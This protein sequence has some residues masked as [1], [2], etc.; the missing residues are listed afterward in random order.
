M[1]KLPYLVS[2]INAA[3]EVYL[4]GRTGQQ[5]NRTAFILCDDAVELASKL[6]L[7]TDNKKWSDKKPGQATKPCPMKPAPLACPRHP[8]NITPAPTEA[9]FK[10]FRDVTA[11]VR[12]VFLA[13]RTATTPTP[14]GCSRVSRTDETDAM[15]SSIQLI[16]S[17]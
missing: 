16:Y 1:S 7:L 5:Y 17:T 6:F 15:A 9:G 10:N 2:E 11:D 12:G 14:T 4:S 13:K 8:A 3:M